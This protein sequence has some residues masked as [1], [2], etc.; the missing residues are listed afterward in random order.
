M[1]PPETEFHWGLFIILIAMAS[2]FP[3]M[4]HESFMLLKKNLSN[5]LYLYHYF[6]NIQVGCGFSFLTKD[7]EKGFNISDLDRVEYLT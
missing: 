5:C 2:H 7:S 6:K 4:M 3:L 1:C